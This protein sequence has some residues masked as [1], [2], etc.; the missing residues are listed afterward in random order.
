MFVINQPWDGRGHQIGDYIIRFLT[1][2]VPRFEVFRVCVA[3]AKASGILQLA[4]ALH[5][6][7]ERGGRVEMVIGIDEGITT[8][9]ALELAMRYSSI[10]HVFNNP[11]A[12]FHPKLYLFEIA[13][14]KAIALIGSSNLTSGG[15]Y[16]NYEATIGEEFDLTKDMDRKSYEGI[17]AIFLNATDSSTGGARL[18]DDALIDELVHNH[19]IMDETR[20]SRLVGSRPR[21]VSGSVALFP[22]LPVPPAPRIH[23][24]LAKLI[25]K[26]PIIRGRADREG[27]TALHPWQTFVMTLGERDTRQ[28]RGF[29]HDIYIPIA[30]R[31][32]S[33]DL[34]GWPHQ[35]T[36]GTSYTRGKYEQRRIDMLIRPVAGQAQIVEGVRLYYYDIKHEFR[37]NCG[38]LVE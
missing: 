38:R 11:A 19:S 14:K 27:I 33:A 18:L 21:K 12:T 24:D 1:Q 20:R 35:F 31:D 29:S 17:L 32:Y 3:F 9:Q 10:V 5:A 30:A 26:I 36:R 23:P 37:L 8:K 25:P 15:M 16:T 4:P 34:W 13:H 2:D 22:R 6:F 28:G 7:M